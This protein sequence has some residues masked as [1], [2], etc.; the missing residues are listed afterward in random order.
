MTLLR[1]LFLALTAYGLFVGLYGAAILSLIMW[2][3]LCYATRVFAAQDEAW[4]KDPRNASMEK[5]T[6]AK[7][8]EHCCACSGDRM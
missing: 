5:P 2:I 6:E 3:F 1:W 8:E 7:T 4:R